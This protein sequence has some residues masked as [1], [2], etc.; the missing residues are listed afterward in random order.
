MKSI[1]QIIT[2]ALLCC[3]LSLHA[4]SITI[5][6]GFGDPA[7]Y[8][9]IPKRDF[10]SGVLPDGWNDESSWNKANCV[11]TCENEDGKTFLRIVCP[12]SERA[13]IQ[14]FHKLNEFAE[15]RAFRVTITARSKTSAELKFFIQAM[16][17]SRIYA[18]AGIRLENDWKEYT[19]TMAGGPSDSKNVGLII[20]SPKPGMVE[21]ASC[22][23]EEMPL[24]EYVPK[25]SVPTPRTESKGWMERFE[26]DKKKLSDL[27]PDFI[28]MGDSIT[29]GW[30]GS[31]EAWEKYIAP[32]NACQFGIAGDRVEHLLWRM[33]NS[34]LGKDF[35]PKL[36]AILI[37]VN[38]LFSADALDIAAGTRTL[39]N[40]IRSASPQTKVLI[41][42]VFPV[43]EKADDVRRKLIQNVNANYEKIA[44]GKDVFFYNF[45][46]AFLEP[47]GTIAK[48]TFPDFV[49]CSPKSYLFY[50]EKLSEKAK[51][52]LGK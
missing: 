19:E 6:S 42:G 38:N 17:T 44:D 27:K 32:M 35:Q 14:F 13:K 12:P 46:D 26:R 43:G 28:I 48:T 31:R 47:D 39:V 10:V 40:E 30:E 16:G 41:L 52:I 50:G 11:Y 3:A 21:I 22:K 18:A 9:E 23:L 4:E 25:T 20:H 29:Q 34:T 8:K 37:G 24:S 36:V 2:A 5:E 7:A 1:T 45:G 49:H 15:R 33:K 51:E